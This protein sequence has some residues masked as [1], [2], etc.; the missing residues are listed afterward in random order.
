MDKAAG[1]GHRLIKRNFS[2]RALR[3]QR[4]IMEIDKTKLEK[5]MNV[6]LKILGRDYQI[7]IVGN[8]NSTSVQDKT[9]G[10]QQRK[11]KAGSV[12]IGG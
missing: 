8:E 12:R 9:S 3:F 1:R 7:R 4:A 10:E 5:A 2:C 11:D 6:A